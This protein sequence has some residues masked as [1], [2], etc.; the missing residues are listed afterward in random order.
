[1]RLEFPE[2]RENFLEDADHSDLVGLLLA[3]SDIVRLDPNSYFA[4]FVHVV[5]ETVSQYIVPTPGDF[6]H[7]IV[8]LYIVKVE[9]S[10][11]LRVS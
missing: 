5:L 10:S 3:S 1:M 11:H 2:C 6:S 4:L 9:S 7:N 8:L